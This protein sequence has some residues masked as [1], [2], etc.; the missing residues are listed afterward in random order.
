MNKFEKTYSEYQEIRLAFDAAEQDDSEEE[1]EMARKAYRAWC[2]SNKDESKEFHFI[3]NAYEESRDNSNEELNFKD[4]I[5]NPE[6]TIA[7]LKANGI[8][9]FTFASGW[10]GAIENAWELQQ[11]G[12]R[13][14]GMAEV[15]G[16]YDSWT[17]KQEIMHALVFEIK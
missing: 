6:T 4:Y 1:R 14:L 5:K 11:A 2:D 12:C 9:K 7:C 13:M 10:S 17:E 16:R 8:K 15:K 3:Y